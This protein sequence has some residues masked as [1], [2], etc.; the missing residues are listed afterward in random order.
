VKKDYQ[1]KAAT[2]ATDGLVMPDSVT[3]AMGELA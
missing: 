3:V 1:I 2:A